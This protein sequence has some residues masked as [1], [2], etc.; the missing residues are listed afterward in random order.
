MFVFVFDIDG[1]L[2]LVEHRRHFV[3]NKPKNWKAFF[4]AMVHD[5][6]NE[7][8]AKTMLSLEAAGHK[9]VLCSGRG[10]EYRRHTEDW[11]KQH[12]LGVYEVLYMRAAG[13]Y[14]PD[15]VVKKELLDQMRSDGYDP[16]AAFDD[17]NSV[18]DMWREN[19]V[20]CFQVAEGDF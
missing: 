1:T 15:N 12:N 20:A 5:E 6:V 16:I 9:I 13:D 19:G 17:R 3:R 11:L 10:E 14:R 2:S 18:V 7:P 8:V 4:E